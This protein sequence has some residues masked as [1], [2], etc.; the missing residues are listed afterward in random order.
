M[1]YHAERGNDQ[2]VEVWANILGLI[3]TRSPW[4]TSE[5]TRAAN[6]AGH[7]AMMSLTHRIRRN[8]AQTKLAHRLNAP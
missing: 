4:E 8:A 6:A 1:R 5:V 2:Q 3:W 7:S